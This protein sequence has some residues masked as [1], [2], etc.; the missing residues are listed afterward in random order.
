[1]SDSE[2]FRFGAFRLLHRQRELLF[3]GAPVTL[4]SRALDLLVALVKR[5]GQLA[6]KDA[7]M[8]E[9]WAGSVVDENNLAAQISALRKVLAADPD[10]ARRLQTVPGRGYRFVADVEV[11]TEAD[12]SAYTPFDMGERP[13][14]VVLPFA[15]LSSDAEQA[16]FAQG[17]SQTVATDLS[18][19]SGLLV[20]SSATAAAFEGKTIDVRQ[21]SR[22]LGVRY[23]LTGSVQRNDRN[24]RI[25]AQL[26]DGHSGLQI[27][28]ERF[29]G[30]AAD[31]LALQDRIT[32]RIANSIGR[33]IFVAAA[34]DGEARNIDPKSFDLFMRGIAA[35]NQPQSLECLREQEDLFARAVQLDPNN[36]DALARLARA[37]LLQATQ[38]HAPSP[39]SE[40]VLARGV[41]AAERAVAIDPG[42]ARAHY[43]MGLVHV[44]R[45]D[46]ERSVLANEAAIALDRNFALAHNNLGNSLVH[47]GDGKEALSSAQTALRLDPRGPQI[48][49]LWTTMGFAR[50]LLAETDEAIS[51]FAR[52]RAANPKLPRAHAGAA[53]ALALGGNVAAARLATADL[54]NLVPHYR[55][56]QTIDACLPGSPP[57]YRQFYADILHPGALRAGVPV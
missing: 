15:N 3:R 20:I 6:T 25:N 13:S 36:S 40:S 54:L 57:R 53:I 29:D 16:Y 41:G 28:S 42:N 21:V 48:G 34:R 27:W 30:D 10:L 12:V 19:I 38:L 56:S 55:L 1:M 2:V 51:C 50:L 11:E 22:D 52:G 35:D 37:I 31:L 49:A 17:L 8:A 24:L 32:G 18:R 4:G 9:V 26:I 47:R 14:L 43:A 7:L 39:P 46:F 5:R 44:L 23:V 33:E 45:G